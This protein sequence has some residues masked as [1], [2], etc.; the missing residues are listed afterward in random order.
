MS[1]SATVGHHIREDIFDEFSSIHK[2]SRIANFSP[3]LC[4]FFCFL[5]TVI[6]MRQDRKYEARSR[7]WV[8]FGAQSAD[9][10]WTLTAVQYLTVGITYR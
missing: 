8:W 3:Y 10:G 6:A 2:I 1:L 5:I 9:W 4:T 7:A